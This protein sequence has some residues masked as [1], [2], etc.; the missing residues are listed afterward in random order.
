MA[1]RKDEVQS[2][3]VLRKIRPRRSKFQP[4]PMTD[5]DPQ[6]RGGD[7]GNCGRTGRRNALADI[8]DSNVVSTTTASLPLDLQ[9][10]KCT[11]DDESQKSNLACAPEADTSAKDSGSSTAPS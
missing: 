4:Y 8:L 9:N 2:K 11:D 10:M 5:V 1:P 7:F 6:Q 3:S